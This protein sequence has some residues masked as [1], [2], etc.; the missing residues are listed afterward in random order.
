MTPEQKNWIDTATYSQLLYRW[1]F[2]PIG[3]P[4]FVGDTGDYYKEKMFQLRDQDPERAV[5]AS[6]DIGW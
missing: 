1:R 3:E 2:A 6:K 5:Q 4:M